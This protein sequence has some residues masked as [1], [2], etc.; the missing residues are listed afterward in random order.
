M[1]FRGC[2]KEIFHHKKISVP[3]IHIKNENPV[4]Y[5]TSDNLCKSCGGEKSV[6]DTEEDILLGMNRGR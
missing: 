4:R 1:T 2:E 6:G 5:D 3:R